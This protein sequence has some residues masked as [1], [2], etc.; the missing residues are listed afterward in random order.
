MTLT[1][2]EVLALGAGSFLAP[3]IPG[4]RP[5]RFGVIA[6]VHHGLALDTEA[7]LEAFL[8]EASARDLDFI[9]QLGDFNHPVRAAR[10]FLRIWGSYKGARHGVLGNHDMDLGSKE[11]ATDLWEV[12]G[13]FYSF[14]AGAHHFVVL[15]ANNIYR[16]RQFVPY[17]DSNY[18]LDSSVIS[19]VDDEQLDWLAAD[20]AAT[21]RQ[22]IV[23]VHQP[24]DET[25]RGGTCQNRHRVRAV[26]EEANRRAGFQKV[27]AVFQG[28][29]HD[30]GYESRRGIHY[31]RV[32]SA[33]YL[34]VGGQYGGMAHYDRSLFAFVTVDDH[35]ISIEGRTAAW[36]PPT[37][38]ERNV[39]D[40]GHFVPSILPRKVRVASPAAL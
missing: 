10:G 11:H 33:S 30:D 22:T 25:Y 40:A 7:R 21:K 20:L 2:R 37:P 12:P 3:L 23:F 4:A 1:R 18:Y 24:I 6:D 13:R 28:H 5:T 15:D 8:T 9:V 27:V 38:A 31:F 29:H 39:P 34:W 26:M 36:V 14:D 19:F 16:D 32:N 17:A 35:E